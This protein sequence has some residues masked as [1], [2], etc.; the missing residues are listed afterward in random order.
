M[1]RIQDTYAFQDKI[2]DIVN[3]YIDDRYNDDD[4]LA[5]CRRNGKVSMTV[6]SP[7]EFR[8]WK[9]AAIYPLEELVINNGDGSMDADNDR[10]SDIANEWV[11]LSEENSVNIAVKARDNS[12][13]S[14]SQAASS[15]DTTRDIQKAK[16]AGDVALNINGPKQD[17]TEPNQLI[18]VPSG[19]SVQSAI[20][21]QGNDELIRN[22]GGMEITGDGIGEC[23][24]Y[25]KKHIKEAMAR[26]LTE[27]CT[28]TKK[29]DFLK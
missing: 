17:D 2:H 28:V 12:L 1:A 11:F 7:N 24:V 27:N 14:Y 29:K 18:T 5:I 4:V 8:T 16:V 22:G 3:D 21:K 25:S 20:S 10:I 26:R 13:G 23:R 15:P 9:T 6:G 19:E